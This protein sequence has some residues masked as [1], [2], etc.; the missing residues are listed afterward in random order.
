MTK[1]R[2]CGSLK[3]RRAIATVCIAI[4]FLSSAF[5]LNTFILCT[6]SDNEVFL[7]FMPQ[8][9]NV[10]ELAEI[11]AENALIDCDD[12]S[13]FDIPI[14]SLASS[15]K[16]SFSA[17]IDPLPDQGIQL[18][19]IVLPSLIQPPIHNRQ[20]ELTIPVVRDYTTFQH[21]TVVLHI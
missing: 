8:Y 3:S 20:A 17:F 19:A 21:L 18:Y 14:N 7:E 10:L 15:S 12:E 6:H 1:S 5:A 13:C 11:E 4:Y 2:Q 9:N 16:S